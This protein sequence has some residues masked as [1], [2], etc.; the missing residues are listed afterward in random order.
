[1][2]G[3]TMIVPSIAFC[4]GWYDPKI[5]LVISGIAAIAAACHLPNTAPKDLAEQ[6]LKLGV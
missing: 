4:R 2:L 5:L 6:P 1:M 3:V